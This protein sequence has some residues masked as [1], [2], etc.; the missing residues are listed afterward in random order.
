MKQRRRSSQRQSEARQQPHPL[1]SGPGRRQKGKLFPGIRTGRFR[2]RSAGPAAGLE[3]RK[4]ATHS[5]STPRA[6]TVNLAALDGV[7]HGSAIVGLGRD[8]RG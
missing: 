5:P 1:S 4:K 6:R 3:Q 2:A 8:L 7:A